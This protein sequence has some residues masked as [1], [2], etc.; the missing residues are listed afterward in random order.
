MT[1]SR[2]E[3]Y[4]EVAP[5]LWARKSPSPP[6]VE[7]LDAIVFDIDGVLVDVSRSFPQV[8]PLAV[9]F[10]FNR[11][12]EVPGTAPLVS[13]SDNSLFKMAGNYNNDWDVMNGAVSYGLLKLLRLNDGRHPTME[14]L[15]AAGPTLEEFT[16]E[17]K[18]RGGGLDNTLAYVRDCLGEDNFSRFQ[19]L[20]KPEVAKKIFMEHY[21]GSSLCRT[22]Y[23]HD[24]EYY[25]GQGLNE[26]EIYLPEL[27]LL[28]DLTG[29]G[30]ALGVLSGRIPSEAHHA[31]ARMG[32]DQLLA[33]GFMVLDDGTLPGKPEPDGLRLLEK[34]MGFERCVYVGDTP[35]DWSTVLNF[36]KKLDDPAVMT[37]CLVETGA[38]NNNRLISWFEQARVDYLA[39]DVNCLIRAMHAG[40]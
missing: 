27:P 18:K 31:L 40:I 37:G 38:Q 1:V 4:L 28:E 26:Q 13:A 3:L 35:D 20:H 30:I 15:S 36:R 10:Y 24:P 16:A 6:A 34:R 21:A 8:L 12:L 14:A 7:S 29:N 17:V 2:E 22:F 9:R 19:S 23:G 5:G 32:F 11:I 25:H 33:A 39:Q